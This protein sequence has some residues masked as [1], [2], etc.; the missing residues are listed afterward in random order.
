MGDLDSQ[1]RRYELEVGRYSAAS[2]GICH[3][4]LTGT[5]NRSTP[6][7]RATVVHADM[8]RSGS[9]GLRGGESGVGDVMCVLLCDLGQSTLEDYPE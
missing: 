5:F 9:F 6:S 1:R 2:W 8:S 7:F 3:I 4:S